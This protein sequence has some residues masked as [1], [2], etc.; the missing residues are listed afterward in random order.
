MCSEFAKELFQRALSAIVIFAAIAVLALGPSAQTAIAADPRAQVDAAGADSPI[1]LAALKQ[2]VNDSERALQNIRIVSSIV[3]ERWDSATHAWKYN[4]EAKTSAWYVGLPKSKAK[5][6]V[7]KDVLPW[8][9]GT[10]PFTEQSFTLAFDGKTGARLDVA[11]GPLKSPR[12]MLEG[13]V[14]GDRPEYLQELND[15]VTGWGY[16]LFGALD[17]AGSRISNLIPVQQT[18]AV[19][20]SHE[21]VNGVPCISIVAGVPSGSVDQYDLDPARGYALLKH[22]RRTKDGVVAQRLTVSSFIKAA[23]GVYFPKDA[24]DENLF[25][26]GGKPGQPYAR[27]RYTA[28]EAVANDP[29]FSDEVFTIKWPPGTDV[30][31]RI[32]GVDYNVP[33]ANKDLIQS[34]KAQFDPAIRAGAPAPRAASKGSPSGGVGASEPSPGGIA[35][36]MMLSVI[37]LAVIIISG[38]VFLR[39]RATHLR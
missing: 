17:F 16:S 7:D 26:P 32:R 10:A 36:L 23:S 30:D 19:S 31:D 24:I 25:A 21:Q 35:S 2:S 27:V 29:A 11:S 34:F 6:Q 28:S 37:L 13:K 4:G 20:V 39:L 5:V 33:Q 15:H 22:E 12:Q 14:T 9:E 3:R 1:D 8:I 18:K 38:I